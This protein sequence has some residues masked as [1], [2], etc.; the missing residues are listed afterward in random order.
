V[1]AIQQAAGLVS[2]PEGEEGAT[3]QVRILSSGKTMLISVMFREKKQ[4][5]EVASGAHCIC[6]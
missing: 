2:S 4:R 6:Q 3:S 5:F 1:A